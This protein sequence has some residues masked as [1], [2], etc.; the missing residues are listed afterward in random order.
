MPTYATYTILASSIGFGATTLFWGIFGGS[1]R[2]A[3]AELLGLLLFLLLLSVATG[4]PTP[5][6]QRA[7][8][9]SAAEWALS[10]IALGTVLGMAANYFFY[11]RR[12]SL[13]SFLRPFFVSPIII[14]P[15]L[16]TLDQ[17]ASYGLVQL[18]SIFI[19]AF[20]NGFFWRTIFEK[21]GAYALPGI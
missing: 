11:L 14:L 3:V 9:G 12:F 4:F 7:F 1:S 5:V 19:I 13:W 20:Q 15:L 21:A 16:G 2:R 8:G 6:E 10:L 18:V 17:T